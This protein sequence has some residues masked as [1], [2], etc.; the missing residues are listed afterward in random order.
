[1]I[2]SMH[3]LGGVALAAVAAC[4]HSPGGE[5][6]A[7]D[8]EPGVVEAEDIEGI[9]AARVED[10]LIG[11][12]PGVRV[13]HTAG[14]GIS[15]R[16]WGPTLQGNQEP[17]YVVDGQPFRVAPGQGL[18]WLNPGDIATIRVLKDVAETARW[19]VQGGNGVVVITTKHG[20]DGP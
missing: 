6:E 9:P 18:T 13:I 4:A 3:I 2:R 19:G 12:F 8:R 5:P 1:M 20:G 16:V 10:H 17:L 11:R 15:V 7:T 14:G